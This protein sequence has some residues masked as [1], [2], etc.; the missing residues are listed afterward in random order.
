MRRMGDGRVP[1]GVYKILYHNPWSSYHL[2]LA[3]SYPNPSD[4]ILGR[5]L[6]WISHKKEE[7]R[8]PFSGKLFLINGLP[9]QRRPT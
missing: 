1:E 2:S 9:E 6:A 4:A 5:R 7:P 8:R 3:V